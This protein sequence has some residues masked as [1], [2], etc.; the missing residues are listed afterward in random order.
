MNSTSIRVALY[1][2]VSTA[3]CDKCGKI[4][5]E[6]DNHSHEFKGQDP[7][8]QLRELREYVERRGW[9]IADV[10]TDVGISGAKAS[11]P[12]LNRLMTDAHRCL[13]DLSDEWMV[14]IEVCDQSQC[15]RS[16][17]ELSAIHNCPPQNTPPR[18]LSGSHRNCQPPHL[19]SGQNGSADFAKNFC[20]LPFIDDS[21]LG[22]EFNAASS[23]HL[24][25]DLSLACRRLC[26]CRR[27]ASGC[28]PQST[29]P[30]TPVYARVVIY[31]H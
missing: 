22:L 21:G 23:V 26:R 7:E 11:R 13:A 27:N 30:H 12:D 18:L 31:V 29:S 24:P 19:A 28:C 4:R 14:E 6:H 25:W 20:R 1:A 15:A 5:T 2:R 10:Y 8:V 9:Q 17:Q 3:K 16:E